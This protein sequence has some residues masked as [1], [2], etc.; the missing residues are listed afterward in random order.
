MDPY[1]R[2]KRRRR[3]TT[4]TGLLAA[5]IGAILYRCQG[6]PEVRPTPATARHAPRPAAQSQAHTPSAVPVA[7][8][9]FDFYLLDL[10]YEAAWCQ[11]GHER[12]GQCAA[13][14]RATAN[15][16]PLVL[17]GL[18]PEN[19]APE[20]YPRNC[21]T[22]APQL[23]AGMRE[24]LASAMPGIEAGLEQHEWRKHGSCSGL[25]AETYYAESLR[26]YQRVGAAL[27]PALRAAVGRSVQAT[28]L[29][30]AIRERDAP[31]ADSVVFVCKNLRTADPG[32]RQ[33][34]YL[35]SVRLCVDNDGPGGRPNNLLVC[36]GVERRDQGCGNS[37]YIDGIEE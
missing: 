4:W 26:L 15:N 25:D 37:F 28:A 5:A 8:G 35:M 31:L 12:R 11:D 2:R 23:S 27:A 30:A 18:W 14:D 24:R 19:R 22:Q 20:S 17:H 29:R 36:A 1:L 32:R 6:E 13:L 16:R 21:D 33:R 3:T 7:V 10:T 34:P 9:R